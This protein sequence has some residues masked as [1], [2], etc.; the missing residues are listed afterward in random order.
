MT[1]IFESWLLRCRPQVLRP[2]ET[3]MAITSKFAILKWGNVLR[4]GVS[5]PVPRTVRD[6]PDSSGKGANGVFGEGKFANL[7]LPSPNVLLAPLPGLS[8][9]SPTVLG[10]GV[11]TP[12]LGTEVGD[13]LRLSERKK[14]HRAA[15]IWLNDLPCSWPFPWLFPCQ[16]FT[17]KQTQTQVAWRLMLAWW[18]WWWS[19]EW[20]NNAQKK[21][22]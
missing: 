6:V 18:W 17:S 2:E 12:L 19:R 10:T 13:K 5:T 4:G 9:T 16:N 22:I 8:G 1:L 11:L 20:W 3:N 7:S 15:S 14:N 21:T